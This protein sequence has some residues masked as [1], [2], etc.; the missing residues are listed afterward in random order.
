MRWLIL[1]RE[2]RLYS[3]QRLKEACE[4]QG[5]QLDILDPNR[6]LLRLNI[7]QG[8]PVFQLFYQEGD[9]YD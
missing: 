1:C 6:M 9:R 4:E 3:C 2:S 8:K 7:E 5:I